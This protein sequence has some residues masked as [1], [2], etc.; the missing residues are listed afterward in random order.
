[1]SDALG[2]DAWSSGSYLDCCGGLRVSFRDYRY[3]CHLSPPPPPLS[4]PPPPPRDGVRSFY[5]YRAQVTLA[6]TPFRD[7]SE[8]LPRHVSPRPV[9][10]PPTPPFCAQSDVDY[11]I[12]N[13]NLANLPGVLKY[14]HSEAVGAHVRGGWEVS[15]KCLGS[16]SRW[17]TRSRTTAACARDTTRS[18][19]SSASGPPLPR[20]SGTPA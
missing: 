7:T 18:R 10:R 15:R 11:P 12:G 16:V 8:T 6:E 1:M 2:G 20:P 13:H 5:I 17:S 3:L 9:L 14:V 19:V 4:P